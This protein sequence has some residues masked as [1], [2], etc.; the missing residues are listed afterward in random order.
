MARDCFSN[1][2]SPKFKGKKTETTAAL[3]EVLI[4]NVEESHGVE[5]MLSSVEEER[6]E[7]EPKEQP[8][9]AISIDEMQSGERR[10]A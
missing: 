10:S 8:S 4:P 2:E 9:E 1:P 5:F 7:K 6:G 3:V